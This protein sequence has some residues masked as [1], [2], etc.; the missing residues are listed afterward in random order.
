MRL[1]F[2][3]QIAPRRLVA[4]INLIELLR[5]CLDEFLVDLRFGALGVA[6]EISQCGQSRKLCDR[7]AKLR[8]VSNLYKGKKARHNRS[9]PHRNRINPKDAEVRRRLLQSAFG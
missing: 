7:T 6:R 2:S 9:D 1:Q 5:F 8:L 4:T 3:L